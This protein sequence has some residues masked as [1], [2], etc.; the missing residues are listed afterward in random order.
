M[1]KIY[2]TRS[3][4]IMD[5]ELKA[6]EI[7]VPENILK[8]FTPNVIGS[9][10][11]PF[12]DNFEIIPIPGNI[13]YASLDVCRALLIDM[14]VDVMVLSKVVDDDAYH[15]CTKTC[16]AIEDKSLKENTIVVPK[17]IL[18]EDFKPDYITTFPTFDTFDGPIEY[19]SVNIE[20]TDSRTAKVSTD[21]MNKI[22]LLHNL[23]LCFCIKEDK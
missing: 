17:I 21:I 18:E 10:A 13:V 8:V 12:E 16:D 15:I 22:D 11:T 20:T 2:E 6:N 19:N 5:P 14:D 23:Q 3:L 4:A 9:F 1:K 7:K